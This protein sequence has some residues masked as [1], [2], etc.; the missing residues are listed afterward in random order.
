M[1]LKVS[2]LT[3]TYNHEP[4]IAQAIESVLAQ[5]LDFGYEQVI[6]EDCSTDRTREIV[7]DYQGRYP[8]RVRVLLREE[9]LGGRRNLVETFR[10][11]RGEYIAWL[12][13]DDYWTS[14]QKLQ[15]QVAFLDAHPGYAICFHDVRKKYE[16][17]AI[18]PRKPSR[19]A[20]QAS[21]TL[22][23]LLERNFIRTCSVLYRNGL[24]DD[25]PDWFNTTPTGDWPLHVLNALHGDIGYIDEVMAVHRVHT[26]SLWSPKSVVERRKITLRTLETFRQVLPSK[27]GPKVEES[28]ARWHFKVL[29]ALALEGSYGEAASYLMELV[30]HG[31]VPRAALLK[32][33]VWALRSRVG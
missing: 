33:A 12:E 11:C 29:N 23:D 31:D 24:F 6:G 20:Y 4:F 14:P 1:S 30:L 7:L 28:M 26:G 32:A 13:G 16:A 21:Y 27:Y 22:E 18:E 5:D 3:T 10:A 8:D 15:K 2:V 17:G 25:F 9:N 19:L